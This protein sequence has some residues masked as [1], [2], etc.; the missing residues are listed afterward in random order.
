MI[1]IKCK[2]QLDKQ[3]EWVCVHMYIIGRYISI[4]ILLI[5][6]EK[7]VYLYINVCVC[8]LCVYVMIHGHERV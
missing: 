2:L 6:S 7:N 5:E 3:Y 4:D 1:T 8:V